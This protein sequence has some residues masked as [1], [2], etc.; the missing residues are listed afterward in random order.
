MQLLATYRGDR[1]VA[2]EYAD[3][4]L[5]LDPAWVMS[6]ANL[7]S[8]DLARGESESARAR[9]EA[10]M[11]ELFDEGLEI[12]RSNI[13]VAI[14]LSLVLKTLG[15][16]EKAQTLLHRSLEYAEASTMPRLHWFGMV[17][18]LPHPISIHAIAGR[19]ALALAALRESIDRGERGLLWYWLDHDPNL[20]SIRGDPEFQAIR[21]QVSS[22]A[23]EQ[24]QRWREAEQP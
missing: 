10:F 7:R 19:T 9:Y 24:L 14:D 13:D 5:R 8:D 20:E 17:Y 12:N 6:L 15:Q 2:T 23:A 21:E 18:G 1:K 16:K 4:V 22:E 11:P 3:R